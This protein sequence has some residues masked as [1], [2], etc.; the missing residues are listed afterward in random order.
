[1]CECQR[2]PLAKNLP[3]KAVNVVYGYLVIYPDL[4]DLFEYYD[5]EWDNRKLKVWKT[6][7]NVEVLDEHCIPFLLLPLSMKIGKTLVFSSYVAGKSDLGVIS[8]AKIDE[9]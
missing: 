1:M 7:V 4:M 9:L 6:K 8:I 3:E 5:V 2:I